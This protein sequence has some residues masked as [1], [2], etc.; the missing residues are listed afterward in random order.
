MIER[1]DF[2]ATSAVNKNYELSITELFKIL[3]NYKFFIIAFVA[4]ITFS[5]SYYVSNLPNVYQSTVIMSYSSDSSSKLLSV[6]SLFDTTLGGPY[7]VRQSLILLTTYGFL[8]SF[9]QEQ[10]FKRKLF[11][12]RF[13]QDK[14]QWLDKYKG[15]P[16]DIEA[17]ELLFSMINWNMKS[18][19]RSNLV[20]LTI[21]WKDPKKMTYVSDLANDLVIE[22]N[23]K[24]MNKKYRD[25]KIEIESLKEKLLESSVISINNDILDLI[26]IKTTGLI[27]HNSKGSFMFNIL[28]PAIA[29]KN[30]L[31]KK[32]PMYTFILFLLSLV[33]SIFLTVIFNHIRSYRQDYN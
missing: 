33:F 14:N 23:N 3:I 12:D 20:Y 28:D 13:D 2:P 19:S 9:I 1:S 21:E 29:P 30:S 26:K 32:V 16:S 4:L 7:K 11:P 17:Y 10:N 22:L 24:M 15:E 25:T 8:V 6:K 5:G 27:I 18:E 31:S